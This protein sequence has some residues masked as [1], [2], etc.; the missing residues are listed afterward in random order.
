[1]RVERSRPGFT[2]H[3]LRA[4]SGSSPGMHRSFFSQS[5]RRDTAFAWAGAQRS[6]KRGKQWH[7]SWRIAMRQDACLS[8][9]QVADTRC[10]LAYSPRQQ[11]LDLA[12]PAG[13][14][15]GRCIGQC[16]ISANPIFLL[17]DPCQAEPALLLLD[18]ILCQIMSSG[19]LP[20][21]GKQRGNQ[22]AI[23]GR[24]LASSCSRHDRL[25]SIL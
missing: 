17:P 5:T 7:A 20:L 3:S 4:G 8:V 24:V 12:S 25:C 14:S 13:S 21:A 9:D 18:N 10:W 15:P 1:V 2:K 6:M 11:A 19:E 22:Q 16:S 23:S